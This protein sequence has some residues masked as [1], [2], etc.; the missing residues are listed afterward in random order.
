MVPDYET[1][2]GTS[3]SHGV[4]CITPE[5]QIVY[6]QAIVCRL[7]KEEVKF[8]NKFESYFKLQEKQNSIHEKEMKLNEIR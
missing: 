5:K 7:G 8:K 1:A 3:K 6:A 4:N 2:L